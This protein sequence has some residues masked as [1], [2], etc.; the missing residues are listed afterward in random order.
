MP[1]ARL[2]FLA[3]LSTVYHSGLVL[4]ATFM[5]AISGTSLGRLNVVLYR[6]FSILSTSL[7]VHNPV[8]TKGL[9]KYIKRHLAN[10]VRSYSFTAVLLLFNFQLILSKF[11][12]I[13]F[14][15]S[16]LVSCLL[17][18]IS[19]PKFLTLLRHGAPFTSSSLHLVRI[20]YFFLLIL[21]FLESSN[22][23]NS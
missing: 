2:D 11:L 18:Q 10:R 3:I 13:A 21:R 8:A 19:I 7:L 5:I 22:F 16:L 6:L 14:S 15:A 9:P 1:A 12:H 23:S 20:S 17:M 4:C